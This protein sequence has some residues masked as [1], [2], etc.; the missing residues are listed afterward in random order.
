MLLVNVAIYG[1]SLSRKTMTQV[2]WGGIVRIWSSGTKT[3]QK[4]WKGPNGDYCTWSA[5]TRYLK[6]GRFYII[7]W[8]IEM[9]E[10]RGKDW[11]ILSSW[12]LAKREVN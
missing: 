11:L 7:W 2:E 6:T 9:L 1:F 12:N 8:V 3:R 10:K 4:A 5:I